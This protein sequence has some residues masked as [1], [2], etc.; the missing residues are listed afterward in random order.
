MAKKK[1]IHF[2]ENLNFPHLF[3]PTYKELQA[4]FSLQG[5]WRRDYF[6]NDNPI[7]LELGC[8]KG[9]YTV[10]L[11]LH[12]PDRNFIG[13]DI[14]GARLWRGSKTVEELGLK[15]VAFIRTKVE[16][17]DHLFEQDEVN[18]LWLTFP[19]PQLKGGRRHKRLT[20]PEFL[21]RYAHVLKSGSIIHLKTDNLD[22]YTYTLGIIN[23]K[24]HQ[25]LFS[26]ADI[27]KMEQAHEATAI[28]TF[29][30]QM[31]RR[32]NIPIKY[33]EFI[34]SDAK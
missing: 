20:S 18:E 23:E 9:E 17:I 28:Q 19:D 25:L 2:A 16:C 33:I 6:G 22:L 24:N 13:I 27:Y 31:F 15:N 1:L 12:K 30:E 4:G 8:G 3:Q 7:T 21:S 11:A 29:Y 26:S 5:K 10:N 32:E 14:K 34:L